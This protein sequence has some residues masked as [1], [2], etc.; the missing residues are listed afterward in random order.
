MYWCVI[1]VKS[2]CLKEIINFFNA[3][4]NIYAFVPKIEK[5]FAN[6]QVR[7]YQTSVMY[8]DYVFIKTSLSKEEFN[9][10]FKH[11]LQSIQRLAH[12]LEY[13]DCIALDIREQALLEKML[14]GGEIV[15]HSIGKI[16]NTVL[17]IEDGPLIGMEKQVKR[18]DRHKRQ[19]VLNC[20][21]LGRIMKVPLEVKSKS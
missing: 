11:T 6:S 21:M 8:P 13:D 5:W 4:E 2:G 15:K 14:N 9:G 3:Q 16:V 1:H 10:K 17:E 7:E 19:A 18:I 12:L 20:D